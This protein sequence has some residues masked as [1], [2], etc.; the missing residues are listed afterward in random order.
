MAARRP[1]RGQGTRVR[2]VTRAKLL[3]TA[4]DM[5]FAG[6]FNATAVDA[7][8]AEAGFTTGAVYSNFGGK[9]DLFLAVIEEQSRAEI[10][11]VRAA[12]VTAR[13]DEE[14]LEVFTTTVGRDPARW[15]GRVAATLEFLSFARQDPPLLARLAEAQHLADA[16]VEELLAS[17]CR[18]LGVEPPADLTELTREVQSLLSGIALRSLFDDFDVAATVSRAISSLITADRSEMATSLQVHQVGS[19]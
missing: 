14:R 4:A 18:A 5:F 1:G 7:I 8:A 6:G 15:Q 17:M 2:E 11:A 9:A 16:A 10:E 13:T 3:R 12:L 19:P